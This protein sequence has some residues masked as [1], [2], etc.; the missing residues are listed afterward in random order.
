MVPIQNASGTCRSS[1]APATKAGVVEKVLLLDQQEQ[2]VEL[3][4]DVEWAVVNAGGHGFYRVS[5]GGDL[6]GALRQALPSRLS[7]VERFGLVNDTWAATLAGLT[8]LTDYLDLIDLLRDEDDVNVWTTVIGSG[9]HLQ[10]I[11]DDGQLPSLAERFRRLLT[12][13]VERLGWTPRKARA[14]W[15]ANCAAI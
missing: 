9:H 7:A 13:A 3:G 15:S 14:N 11:L 8:P 2:R 4:G 10:R 12:P 1:C 5:Y 6:A